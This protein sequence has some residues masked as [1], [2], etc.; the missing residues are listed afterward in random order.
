[1]GA[2]RRIRAQDLLDYKQRRD[3]ERNKALDELARLGQ[4][5]DEE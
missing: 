5:I 3:A 4:E 2:H 1:V